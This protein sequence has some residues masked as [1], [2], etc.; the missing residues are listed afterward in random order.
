M[1]HFVRPPHSSSEGYDADNKLAPGSLW[2][3]RIP[4][5]KTRTVALWGG[6]GLKVN[7]NNPSVVPNDRLKELP[8]SDGLRLFELFG[9]S[10]G[11]SWI[12]VWG[13][14]GAFWIRLQALVAAA[15][16][17]ATASQAGKAVFPTMDQCGI[18]ALDEI[19]SR[20]ITEGAEFA[21]LIYKQGARFGFTA[22]VRGE[23]DAAL[24]MLIVPTGGSPADIQAA[25]QRAIND[26][27]RLVPPGTDPVGTYH[28]HGNKSGSGEIFSP[29]D[30]GFHNLRHWFAYLGTP[31]RRILKLTPKDRPADE[32]VALAAFGGK[33]EKLRD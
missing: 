22:P 16:A 26:A 11:G 31:S 19:L 5:G 24:P 25:I 18:A 32:N 20:S 10:E 30:R 7:S 8:A 4:L 33:A 17:V 12:D 15:A 13:P 3:V 28:T 23:P 14:D 1:A 29:Q 6:D 9:A 21:G 27:K 2:R